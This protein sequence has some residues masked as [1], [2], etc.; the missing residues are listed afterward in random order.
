MT[1]DVASP[2]PI[3]NRDAWRC[4]TLRTVGAQRAHHEYRRIFM[5]HAGNQLARRLATVSPSSYV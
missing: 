2:A 1:L 4:R 3:A 5:I